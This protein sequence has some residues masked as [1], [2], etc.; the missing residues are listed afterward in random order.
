MV[1]VFLTW[2]HAHGLLRM[3]VILNP[4]KPDALMLIP[5]ER[6]EYAT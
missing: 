2:S 1:I 4:E 5:A 3:M 6:F